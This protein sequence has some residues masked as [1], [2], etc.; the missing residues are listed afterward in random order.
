MYPNQQPP[1]QPSPQPS[2]QPPASLQ[3]APAQQPPTKYRRGVNPLLVASI[4]LGILS[5]GLAGFSA[6]AFLNYQ[7]QKN[8]TDTKIASAVTSAKSDQAKELEKQFLEREKQ[9]YSTFTGP[10]DFGHVTFDYPKTWSVY[11]GKNSGGNYEAYLNPKVVPTVSTTQPYAARVVIENDSYE[12][13]LKGFEGAVTK[14][15]LKSNPITVNG[16]TGVRLDGQFTKEREGSTVV[17]KVR[18]KTLL[19]STDASAFRA[20]FDN[21]VLKSLDFNP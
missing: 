16:F 1:V 21:I 11:V 20:D 4:V 7:D 8:N 18:D 3:P 5:A 9:P 13:V 17:F 14:G 2:V 19:V 15:A 10:D 12:D 6:W